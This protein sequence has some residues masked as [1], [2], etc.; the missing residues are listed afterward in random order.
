MLV[1]CKAAFAKI[2]LSEL[3]EFYITPFTF[4]VHAVGVAI[5]ILINMMT[6][7]AEE[8]QRAEL[9]NNASFITVM[10]WDKNFAIVN[11]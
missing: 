4:S 1:R 8:C 2:D 7:R 5:V 9:R 6:F 11:R 3:F 10:S